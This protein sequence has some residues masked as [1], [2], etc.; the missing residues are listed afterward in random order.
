M[1]E[2][3][4]SA[5]MRQFAADGLRVVA[6]AMGADTTQQENKAPEHDLTLIALVGI[7]DP[8]RADVPA[9]V[10]RCQS[11]GVTVRMLTGDNKLTAVHIAIEC[12][13]L[14]RGAPADA[15]MEGSEFRALSDAQLLPAVKNLR[16][17]ARASPQD[18]HRLVRALRASGEV[19][20][21]TGD[22]TNDAPQL[23]EVQTDV[24]LDATCAYRLALG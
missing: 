23:K 3:Q 22:G 1:D 2:K 13:V 20:A 8:V 6:V 12:G 7:K 5:A 18:K 16:V 4:I 21:V 10:K 11:A 19:V 9:A 15:V 24:Y 14:P 17:L